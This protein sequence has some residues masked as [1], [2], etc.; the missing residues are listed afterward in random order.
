MRNELLRFALD[1]R[2]DEEGPLTGKELDE[3]REALGLV[4]TEPTDGS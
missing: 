1:R 2:E 4:R 3:A